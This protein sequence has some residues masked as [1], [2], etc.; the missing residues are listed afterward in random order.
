MFDLELDP[1]ETTNIANEQP[2]LISQLEQSLLEITSNPEN[3]VDDDHDEL[4]EDEYI[5][6]RNELKRLGYI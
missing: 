1:L 3:Y 5:K 4:S 6:T 2:S